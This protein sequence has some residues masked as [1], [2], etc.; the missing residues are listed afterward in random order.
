M[1]KPWGLRHH[2]DMN[3]PA[4]RLVLEIHPGSNPIRGRL[5][6]ETS[7]RDFCGWLEFAT[8]LQ[9]ALEPPPDQVREPPAINP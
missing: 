2:A 9:A 1:R 7:A 5:G 6:D 3:A 8:A 4:K